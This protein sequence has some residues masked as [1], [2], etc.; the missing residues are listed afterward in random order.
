[1][2]IK[3]SDESRIGNGVT[4]RLSSLGAVVIGVALVAA[5]GLVTYGLRNT[6]SPN[7]TGNG[8]AYMFAAETNTDDYSTPE[9]RPMPPWGEMIVRDFDLE[10]PEEYAAYSDST[11]QVERWTF[12]GMDPAQVRALMLSCGLTT[13]QTEHALLASSV[14]STSSNTVV[15]P[16]DDLVFSLPP[17]ARAKLY[18]ELGRFAANQF[19]QSPVSIRGPA[20]DAWFG[21]GKL[22]A[23][24]FSLLKKLAY[25]RGD[26]QCLSDLAPLVRR[27]PDDAERIRLLRAL[28]RQ[29]AVL[30]GIHVRPDTDIDK[31]LG[32]WD[33]PPGVRLINIRPLLE[34]LQRR[35]NG[36][37][38]SI[39]YFLPPFARQRLYTYPLPS[40]PSDPIM[41]CHW[42]TM[43][44][45]NETPDNRFDDPAYTLTYIR[46]HY[47]EVAKPIA[48]GDII[49][50]V[51]DQNIAVHSAVYLADDI[52]FTKNG[53]NF[54]HP[55]MLMRLE[56]LLFMYNSSH[57]PKVVVYRNKDW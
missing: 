23:G 12:E 7:S 50:L 3:R 18:D 37:S 26:I 14:L 9:P 55:W 35:P 54:A 15:L 1:M 36:G 28:S 51:N 17:P 42:S 25:R 2:I 27:V 11:N 13:S 22:S 16:D 45:F 5:A 32:Y 57:P 21:N 48:Y 49:L 29:A 20:F 40:S 52:F 47:Y 30:V 6:G 39:L 8:Q 41:D 4:I 38:A 10:Q 44:F 24:T 46:K 56:D 53:S 19:M 43:N 33:R 34:S 31:L